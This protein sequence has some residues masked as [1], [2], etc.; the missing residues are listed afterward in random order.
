MLPGVEGS[1]WQF[2]DTYKG[3][4]EAG[5]DRAIDI[6]E[7]G[8]RPFASLTNLIN[9]P[10]NRKRAKAIAARIG[11]YT[12]EH[13][14]R[15]ITLVGYSG[16]GGLAVLA[17]ESL[18]DGVRL[19]RLILIGAALSPQYDLSIALSRCRDG[20]VNLYS[21]GDWIM[22]GLGT[23]LFGTIDRVRTESAGHVGFQDA[24]GQLAKVKGLRQVVWI[25]EWSSLGHD[26][27]HYGWLAQPWAR[28]ILA[29][30][31]DPAL[32]KK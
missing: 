10:L 26:G 14:D 22:L 1:A 32:A 27:G 13:P 17:V 11:K 19:D 29:P 15:P 6:V 24:E 4:R 9:L 28:D 18:D 16:G 25:R 12:D 8:G 2:A 21:P 3:L 5:V 30:E 23:K 7:W 20:I 31:I